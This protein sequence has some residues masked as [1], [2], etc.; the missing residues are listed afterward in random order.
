MEAGACVLN[1]VPL[2]AAVCLCAW[3]V[4]ASVPVGVGYEAAGQDRP[5]WINERS[6]AARCLGPWNAR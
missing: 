5:R 1:T 6:R 4:C 2:F 3:P